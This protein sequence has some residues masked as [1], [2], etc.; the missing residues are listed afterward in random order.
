[1]PERVYALRRHGLTALCLTQLLIDMHSLAQTPSAS[2]H[3]MS[4]QVAIQTFPVRLQDFEK[5]EVKQFKKSCQWYQTVAQRLAGSGHCLDVF[6]CSLDQVGIAEMH[7][8]ISSS[9]EYRVALCR[10]QS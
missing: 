1:M 7:E 3:V 2:L 6:A 9:G 10:N 8:A 5:G 4:N